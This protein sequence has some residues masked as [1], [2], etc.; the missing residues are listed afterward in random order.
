[1]WLF[2]FKSI[3]IKDNLM[4]YC[5]S[6][7]LATFQVLK[8]PMWLVATVLDGTDTQHFLHHSEAIDHHSHKWA[9]ELPQLLDIQGELKF[10]TFK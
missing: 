5:S 4:F 2:N 10:H 8:H 3:K 7:A 1:M 9:P 6:V